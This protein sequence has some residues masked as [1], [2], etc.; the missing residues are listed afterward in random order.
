MSKGKTNR[1]PLFTEAP[2]EEI[3]RHNLQQWTDNL[4]LAGILFE[5][6]F[7]NQTI[8]RGSPTT[9]NFQLSSINDSDGFLKDDSPA[10]LQVPIERDGWYA[11]DLF[12]LSVSFL[13]SGG[14]PNRGILSVYRNGTIVC[15]A[16]VSLHQRP[17]TTNYSP[18]QFTYGTRLTKLDKD[19]QITFDVFTSTVSAGS[20][21]FPDDWAGFKM[22]RI[23]F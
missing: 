4:P 20:D 18:V 5:A 8:T 2:S 11:I 23:A 16:D 15:Y 19:D 13:S 7:D 1:Y 22:Y 12:W 10:T 21:N 9:I 17:G 3:F 6:T 14:S